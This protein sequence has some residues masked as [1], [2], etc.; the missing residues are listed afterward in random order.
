MR[1]DRKGTNPYL[2][3]ASSSVLSDPE[4]WSILQTLRDVRE[5]GS[6]DAVE[7]LLG[8]ASSALDFPSNGPTAI[9]L[10]RLL[11]LGW[12][13]CGQ[14]LVQDRFGVFSLM[15]VGWDELQLRFKLSWGHVLASAVA[16]RPTFQGLEYVD[17]PELHRV[18]AGFGQADQVFLRCHL[19][20]TLFTQ[21]A[22]AK[23]QAGVTSKCPWCPAQDGFHHR[24][25]ICPHFADCQSHVTPPQLAALSSLPACLVDHGWPVVLPEWE[26][27]CR[28]LLGDDGFCRMSPIGPQVS[29]PQQVLDLFLDGTSAFPAEAKLRFAAWAVTIAVGESGT[30]DNRL[31]MGGHVQG[32]VQSPFRAELTA[33]L[34]AVLWAFQHRQKVRLWCDC[35]S[36]VRG[37]TRLLQGRL[38]RRNAPHSD[39]WSQMKDV[40]SGSMDLI[41]IRKVV[42]HGQIRRATDPVEEW[43]Y[44]HNTLTD[45][46]AESINLRRS[47]DFFQAWIGLRDALSFHRQ[48]HHSILGVLL[49]TSRK[50][51]IEQQKKPVVKEAAPGP[52]MPSVPAEWVIPSRLIKRYGLRNLEILH[53]WWKQQGNAMLQGDRPLVYV[54]RIQLYYAFNLHSGYVGPW[55]HK[56]KWFSVG[57]EVPQ[58]AQKS[59][60]DRCKLFLMMWRTYLKAQGVVV[61]QKMARPASSA[62]A[63]W[64][65][66]YRLR[67]DASIIDEID[68]QIFSQLGR[69]VVTTSDVSALAPARTG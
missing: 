23:F 50:A 3:L 10:S 41:Q 17:L 64:V 30:L 61:P 51:I 2:H 42:S 39:L 11:R 58:A 59:W 1:A 46:A 37:V 65:V 62:V 15:S 36:V 33:A 4:A 44:W 22:R 68:H 9:L 52:V 25:W 49:K 34:Q 28:F 26:L 53:D 31:L 5:L 57:S 6:R 69:Q 66:S 13:V 29:G 35:Q 32:M 27:F 54:S 56:K 16:H 21:S 20:G 63:K 43:A 47:P 19:D 60:G 12:A 45:Q 7:S 8:L 24:A 40:L 18:L 14:G 55:C 48:L 38:P 67:W